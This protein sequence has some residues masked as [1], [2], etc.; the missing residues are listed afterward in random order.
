MSEFED[1]QK[2][3]VEVAVKRLDKLPQ[4]LER[5]REYQRRGEHEIVAEWLLKFAGGLQDLKDLIEKQKSL[6]PAEGNCNSLLSAEIVGLQKV[7]D[8]LKLA[9]K[10]IAALDEDAVR[11]ILTTIATRHSLPDLL[12]VDRKV[13]A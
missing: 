11:D 4:N 10:A 2:R 9:A 1:L 3:K 6:C 7:I 13:A 8:N 12:K 5:M